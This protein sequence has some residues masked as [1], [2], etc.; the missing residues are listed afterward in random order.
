MSAKLSGAGRR[1]Y[2]LNPG[3][4]DTAAKT[5]FVTS[6]IERARRAWSGGCRGVKFAGGPGAAPRRGPAVAALGGR[7][8]QA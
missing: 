8:G 1:A 7:R 5:E 4:Q 6:M 2:I 3:R